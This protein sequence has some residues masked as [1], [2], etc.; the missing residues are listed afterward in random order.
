MFLAPSSNPDFLMIFSSFTM[1]FVRM[2][3]STFGYG[4]GSGSGSSS[5]LY[6]LFYCSSYEE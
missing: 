5:S 4:S 3:S 2:L 6:S 1:V